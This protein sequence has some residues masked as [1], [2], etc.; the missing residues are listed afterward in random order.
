MNKE[1]NSRTEK[2]WKEEVERNERRSEMKKLEWWNL[3]KEENKQ[4]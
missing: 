3:E 1:R 2:K 4:E